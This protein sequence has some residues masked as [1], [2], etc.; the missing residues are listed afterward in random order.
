M[1]F[2]LFK[3]WLNTGCRLV[4]CFSVCVDGECACS[5]VCVFVSDGVNFRL[6]SVI[7]TSFS[8]V[9]GSGGLCCLFVCGLL[10]FLW[11]SGRAEAIYYVCCRLWGSVGW[12]EGICGV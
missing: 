8:S 6:V 10:L 1:W 12:C 7:I 3:K 4:E 9:F 2:L 11:S 5:R